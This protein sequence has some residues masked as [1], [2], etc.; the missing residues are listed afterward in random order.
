MRLLEVAVRSE[1]SHLFPL[2][3][4]FK[5]GPDLNILTRRTE[6]PSGLDK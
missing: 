5:Y 4:Y 6:S 2:N 1:V 3:C